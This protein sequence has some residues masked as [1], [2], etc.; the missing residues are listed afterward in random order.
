MTQ[1]TVFGKA[2]QNIKVTVPNLYTGRLES[3]G[4]MDSSEIEQL[5]L[6][7]SEKSEA[8]QYIPKLDKDMLISD[9]DNK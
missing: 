7:T 1:T 3:V 8:L 4:V 2:S 9:Q 5:R 6:K